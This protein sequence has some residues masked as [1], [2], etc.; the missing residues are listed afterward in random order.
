MKLINILAKFINDL[1]LEYW[2][3][4]LAVLVF[5]LQW[6]LNSPNSAYVRENIC[7]T[8]KAE[9]ID[10]DIIKCRMSRKAGD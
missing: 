7:R 6:L 2:L 8:E 9:F 10:S 5:G 3:L 4:I 1:S